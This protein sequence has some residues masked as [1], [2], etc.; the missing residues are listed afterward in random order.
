M[1]QQQ[2]NAETN[3]DKKRQI[4]LGFIQGHRVRVSAVLRSFTDFVY[5]NVMGSR[6]MLHEPGLLGD[7]NISLVSY[8][9]RRQL[10]KRLNCLLSIVLVHGNVGI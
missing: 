1:A 10:S 8:V 2:I 4:A 7:V 3:A 9:K 6:S 5:A